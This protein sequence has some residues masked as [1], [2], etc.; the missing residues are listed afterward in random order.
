M[1]KA[2]QSPQ[3]PPLIKRPITIALLILGPLLI[4][5]L[6]LLLVGANPIETYV[7]MLSNTLGNMQGIGE[8][9][10]RA[11]PLL[12]A[13]LATIVPARAGLINVGGEGQL[14]IGALT[15]VALGVA[16]GDQLPMW[17]TLPLLAIA[18]MVGGLLWA[19][20]AGV[21]RVR[22]NLNETICTLLLNYVAFLVVGMFVNGPLKDP[23][24]F[25]WPFSP[26]LVDS[27]RFPLLGLSRAHW[28]IFIA[29]VVAVLVWFVTSK[30]FIGLRMRVVG[31]NPEAA[32]RA[33]IHV[34]RV[35]LMAMLVG[36]ALAGLG[37][38]IQTSGVEGR[39]L[40]TTG[41]GFGYAGFLAAWMAGQHPL[42]A[43]GSALLL[44][45]IAVSGDTLQL[46]ASLPASSINILTAAVLLTVLARSRK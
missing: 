45:L 19:A 10:V 5:A 4:F 40:P 43:I 24:S 12:L 2:V 3:L 38:M 9:A 18:G 36:G 8:V 1:V 26:P 33:G 32:K 29:P 11:A 46:A 7:A 13:A 27:A 42:W 31:G 21:L 28:G 34:S 35:Q 20:I 6:F 17:I 41:V 14:T 22:F 30:T 25:N 16:I 39:L 37:G 44:A 15:S 23:A